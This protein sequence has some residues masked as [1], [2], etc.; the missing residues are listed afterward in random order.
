[1]SLSNY[2]WE[3]PDVSES[4]GLDYIPRNV[5]AHLFNMDTGYSVCHRYFRYKSG[6]Q[7]EVEYNG[8]DECYCKRCLRKYKKLE[9]VKE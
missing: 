1:M 9:E 2:R 6:A 4:R 7:D 3:V 8:R 5:K